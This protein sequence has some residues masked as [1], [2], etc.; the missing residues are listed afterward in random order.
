MEWGRELG[1]TDLQ[2]RGIK[3]ILRNRESQHLWPKQQGLKTVVNKELASG[4]PGG[5]VVKNPPANAGDT[6]RA[7][8]Q[9]DP[10]CCGATKP[11]HHNYWACAL[12]P[13]SH[14][15]WARVLQL[16]KPA[17]LQPVLR[18][19]RSHDNEKPVHRK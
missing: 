12:G 2:F 17:C 3:I 5:A 16:L 9:E 15:Y 8:D 10:T 6:V 1:S 7:L 13:A 19:K 4:F 11:M 18:N 14:I